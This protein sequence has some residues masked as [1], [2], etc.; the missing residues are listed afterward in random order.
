MLLSLGQVLQDMLQLLK[1]TVSSRHAERLET[2]VIWLIVVEI[3]TSAFTHI[4]LSKL[5]PPDRT[6]HNYDSCR[7]VLMNTHDDGSG[8]SRTHQLFGV[9]FH[10]CLFQALS[11]N[12]DLS[13]VSTHT[14]W[15]HNSHL[16]DHCLLPNENQELIWQPPPKTVCAL[17]KLE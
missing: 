16:S 3:G 8:F 12:V 10:M 9:Y 5:T 14:F 13:S 7:L 4:H 11:Y 15:S 6:G 2:I 17:G 1:E